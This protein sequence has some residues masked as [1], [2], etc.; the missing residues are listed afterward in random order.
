MKK[1]NR[2]FRIGKGGNGLMWFIGGLGFCGSLL[3]FIL[4]FIPP[5]QIS[6]GSNTVWFSVLIIGALV[7]VA[8]P[9]IIY[10]CKKPSWVDPNTNFEPFHWEVQPQ[11]AAS[12]A[13]AT[14]TATSAAK[15]TVSTGT[16]ST[17]TATPHANPTSTSTG[18][19]NNP[20]TPKS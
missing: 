18:T 13:T 8:A 5:S 4:S 9:F 1:L 10:A 11:V 15:A 20:G 12:A 2:P 14:A 7:V 6:T 3:A 19:T 17:A 16:T